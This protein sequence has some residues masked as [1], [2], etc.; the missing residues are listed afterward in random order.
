MPW[1]RFSAL[2][3]F[4]MALVNCAKGKSG[5]STS[6]PSIASNVAGQQIVCPISGYYLFNG[7][8]YP[9]TPGQMVTVGAG[10]PTTPNPNPTPTP[11]GVPVTPT[12]TPLPTGVPP[13]DS[14]AAY[15]AQYPMVTYVV[16][17]YQGQ[18]VCMRDDIAIYYGLAVY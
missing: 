15:S 14:C 1:I 13:K 10:V 3:F 11:G 5:P 17:Y 18:Y 4:A 8:N 9:C 2:I 12:P 16:A 6:A 7:T